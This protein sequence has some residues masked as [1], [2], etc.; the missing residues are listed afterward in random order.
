CRQREGHQRTAQ[1]GGDAQRRRKRIA[2]GAIERR[3][4][5]EHAARRPDGQLAELEERVVD[6]Q[7]D[8]SVAVRP[9]GSRALLQL[10]L[11]MA[12]VLLEVLGL[13]KRA[14]GPED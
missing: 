14:L 9:E 13:E 6:R 11:Q 4:V 8:E 3:A 2:R 10:R 1:A 12:V 7:L 5:R